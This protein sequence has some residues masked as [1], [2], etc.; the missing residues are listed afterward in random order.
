MRAFTGGTMIGAVVFGLINA[1]N[2]V[3]MPMIAAALI[4]FIISASYPLLM[5]MDNSSTQK[6]AAKRNSRSGMTGRNGEV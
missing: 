2:S 3:R 4:I 5:L 6:P 1:F